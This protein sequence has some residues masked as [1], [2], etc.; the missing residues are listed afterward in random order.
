MGGTPAKLLNLGHVS[1]KMLL[2]ET[3]KT[4]QLPIREKENEKSRD[5]DRQNVLTTPEGR[6]KCN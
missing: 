6:D 3:W 1:A 4:K 5:T 2:N